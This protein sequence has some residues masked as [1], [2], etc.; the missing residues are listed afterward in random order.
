[1]PSGSS[2]PGLWAPGPAIPGNP[3]LGAVDAPAAMM[4]NGKILCAFAQTPYTNATSTN[5]FNPPTSFYE[6][7]FSVGA[8]GAFAQ[9]H[10]P[11][12]GFTYTGSGPGAG[13]TFADRMLDLPDG[14]VL[15][16]DSSS[17]L[18]VYVPDGSPMAVGK[19]AI[20][21]VTWNA[22]GSLHL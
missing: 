18:Y 19:A 12:G 20:Q 14:T 22:D 1:L 16:A 5:V 15:F 2:D 9:V 3:S 11:G 4:V 17:Q 7:D 8:A 6:Y 13:S 21:S 10:A